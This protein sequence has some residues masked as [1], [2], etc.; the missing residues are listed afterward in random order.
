[1]LGLTKS[2]AQKRETQRRKMWDNYPTCALMVVNWTKLNFVNIKFTIINF[3]PNYLLSILFIATCLYLYMAHLCER[4]MPHIRMCD[5]ECGL[6]QAANVAYASGWHW[7]RSSTQAVRGSV[8]WLTIDE[9]SG[10]Q[11]VRYRPRTSKCVRHQALEIYRR[12]P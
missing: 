1:M 8:H 6:Q 2:D 3:L 7:Q 12:N 5:S 4:D 9:F 11:G 10:R